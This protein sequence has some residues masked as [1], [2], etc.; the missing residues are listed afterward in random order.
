MVPL[1]EAEVVAGEVEARIPVDQGTG[2]E[3][4]T[5]GEQE[6]EKMDFR[7]VEGRRIHTATVTT[8]IL[9]RAV[10]Q[11]ILIICLGMTLVVE[12]RENGKD[13]VTII[14]RLNEARNAM[15]PEAGGAGAFR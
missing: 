3:K 6:E 7:A 10:T 13:R 8:I 5:S 1:E 15:V 14:L 2:E 11:T 12:A 4:W 9:G